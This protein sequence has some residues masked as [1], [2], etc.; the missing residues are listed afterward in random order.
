MASYLKDR[1]QYIV[2]K[3]EKGGEI[4]SEKEKVLRGVPQCSVLGP[5]LY[6]LYMNDV[7]DEIFKYIFQYADDTSAVVSINDS[8]DLTLKTQECRQILEN[9]F[10]SNNLKLNVSKT[11]CLHFKYHKPDSHFEFQHKNTLK[12]PFLVSGWMLHLIGLNILNTWQT[13]L[14]DIA[15]LLECFPP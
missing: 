14:V 11:Q 15:T 4:I 5:L 9:W 2:E 13:L 12:L 10:I 1:Y 7:L 3:N 6:I 8:E